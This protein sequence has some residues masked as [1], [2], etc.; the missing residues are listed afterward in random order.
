MN[1]D[2]LASSTPARPPDLPIDRPPETLR[3][4]R[5]A[6][7][8][9]AQAVT[10]LVLATFLDGL[11]I[12]TFWTALA[13]V[14][15][16]AAL[17]TIVWPFVIRISLPLVLLTVGLFTFVLNA[18]FVSAAA[19]IVGGIEISSFNALTS[20][21]AAAGFNSPPMSLMHR[22]CVPAASSSLAIFT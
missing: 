9:A 18:L 7:L 11:K 14:V 12:D 22:I 3:L 19:S 20:V 16:L 15:V 10:L 17:N 4:A 13:M 8:A 2:L 5:I 21:L 1:A 6:V